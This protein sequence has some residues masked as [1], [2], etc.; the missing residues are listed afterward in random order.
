MEK[1]VVSIGMRGKE[2]K[3]KIPTQEN[4]LNSLIARQFQCE[5]N[6]IQQQNHT[7]INKAQQTKK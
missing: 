2:R 4:K 7:H 3:K 1:F 6:N 5:F